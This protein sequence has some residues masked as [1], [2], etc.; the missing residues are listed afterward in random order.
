MASN[1]NGKGDALIAALDKL[2]YEWLA[3]NAPELVVA[4]GNELPHLTPEGIRFVVQKHVGADR[5]GLAKRCE[6][7]AR[8]IHRLSN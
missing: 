7:A 1:G 4:I 8:H 6:Q 3:T 2:S 5:E